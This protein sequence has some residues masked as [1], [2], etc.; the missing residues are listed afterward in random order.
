[1]PPA[2]RPRGRPTEGG[3]PG[4]A[5]RWETHGALSLSLSLDTCEAGGS[6]S[7]PAGTRPSLVPPY[8]P[9]GA[10]WDT[11]SASGVSCRA[12]GV[13][14]IPP[15]HHPII[16]HHRDPPAV[17]GPRHRATDKLPGPQAPA[18]PHSLLSP[19]TRCPHPGA[20]A[21]STQ[22]HPRRRLRWEN[23]LIT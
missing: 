6:Q 5:P 18:A 3:G 14:L 19:S 2:P 7:T 15:R 23:P 4:D 12:A 10:R 8:S 16:P 11:A 13:L 21:T 9:T 1:M 17:P 20:A 22:G